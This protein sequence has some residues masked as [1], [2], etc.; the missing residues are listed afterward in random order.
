MTT[1]ARMQNISTPD[2]VS[3]KVGKPPKKISV[4]KSLLAVS[5]DIGA[6]LSYELETHDDGVSATGGMFGMI[7][8]KMGGGKS[9]LLVQ[10]AQFANHVVGMA[11]KWTAKNLQNLRQ[12]ET[13][14]WRGL[15]YDHWNCLIPEYWGRSFPNSF[16]K[17]IRL[18]V[19][20]NDRLTHYVQHGKKR[21]QL[22]LAAEDV[23][24]YNTPENLYENLLQGGINVVYEPQEYYLSEKTLARILTAQ[25]KKES[26][27]K[28]E[29]RIRAPSAMWW[30]E[31]IETLTRIK[32]RNE[33]YTL[34]LD[35]ADDIFPF[36][37][38]GS[39][40][41][42]IGW[43]TRTVIHLRKNN[44]STLI[45]TQDI[46]LV[47]HRIYDRA[48]Y[49]IWLPGARPKNRISMVNQNLIRT[50]PKGWG[51]I[52]EANARF[53]RFR[54]ERIPHQPPLVQTIGLSGL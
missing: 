39:N 18:H 24:Y 47:D 37:A 50:L 5:A 33:Y 27:Y 48:N 8:G 16:P 42:L 14:I 44:I 22:M 40:W 11:D 1:E 20:Y 13:V 26:E 10:Y 19:H 51:I 43:F 25:L 52:E 15:E 35:E 31:F 46:N 21:F 3:E 38:Q 2:E 36:G 6:S 9:T 32:A 49:F 28:N 45:A 12:P 53:G 23:K 17:K 29:E 54:F 34:I 7:L 4:S 30:Y 41:H